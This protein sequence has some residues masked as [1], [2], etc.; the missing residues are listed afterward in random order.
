MKILY[1]TPYLPYPLN[2]GTHQRVFHLLKSLASAHQVALF[3][4]DPDHLAA[5]HQGVFEAFC[6][7]V[8]RVPVQLNPWRNLAQRLFSQQPETM[9]H[10][11]LPAVRSQLRKL[12]LTAHFD[13]I[14]AEDICLTQYLYDLL[15]E[16]APD[17]PVITDRNRVDLEFMQESW[18]YIKG[19]KAR[20]SFGENYLKLHRL[21]RRLIQ[22]FPKQVVCSPEDAAFL[23]RNFGVSPMIIG[24]GVDHHY[25][26]PQ[27]WARSDQEPVLCFTGA[28]D[29]APNAEGITWFMQAVYPLLREKIGDFRLR[30]V[31]LNPGPEIQAFSAYPGVEVTG[32]VPD[33]R[34]AYAACDVY[35][36]PIRIGGGT[37]L[38]IIEAMAMGKPVVSTPTGAQGL[39][40][41]EGKQVRFGVSPTAFAA[42]IIDLLQHPQ[43]SA[44]MAQA[45]RQHVLQHFTW[46]RLGENL[47]QAVNQMFASQAA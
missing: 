17:T 32:G 6:E 44:Q 12:L 8:I 29:Y 11:D 14:F 43:V 21:E 1:L 22:R 9:F 33:I 37:R 4:L 35:I 2:R 40:L 31:G 15:P 25:F 10:W 13:L 18:P 27:I 26:S 42:Q 45:G 46:E 28:M 38:K 24:N 19:I 39:G 7:R 16:V 34:P 47:L 20:A 30:I 41:I 23:S 36:A 3:S 5:A